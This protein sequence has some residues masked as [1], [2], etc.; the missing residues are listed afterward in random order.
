PASTSTWLSRLAA[1]IGRTRVRGRDL[2]RIGARPEDAIRVEDAEVGRAF[3]VD[4]A[5]RTL[6]RRRRTILLSSGPAGVRIR[7]GAIARAS[8][9]EVPTLGLG[10]EKLATFA[11]ASVLLPHSEIAL[12]VEC[13]R[14]GANA[15]G[16]VACLVAMIRR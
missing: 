7:V 15:R 3:D 10:F 4:V 11:E 14:G 9:Y 2:L 1:P 8:R 6:G 16:G 5:L 12:R 13:A